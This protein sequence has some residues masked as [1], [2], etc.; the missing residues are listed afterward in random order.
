LLRN[1]AATLASLTNYTRFMEDTQKKELLSIVSA[2]CS[3]PAIFTVV[4]NH[5]DP[6]QAG[7]ALA[8]DPIAMAAEI[9]RVYE[10]HC[11]KIDDKKPKTNNVITL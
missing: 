7:L 11:G 1:F 10:E 4:K 3:N 9:H 2:L 6:R 8:V 5:I